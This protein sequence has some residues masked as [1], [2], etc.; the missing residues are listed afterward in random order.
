M[1]GFRIE[2]TW[3]MNVQERMKSLYAEHV[4]DV[5]FH[6][7]H[8]IEFVV[9]KVPEFA[10]ELGADV[11]K[12][13]LAALVHDV[14]HLVA[15]GSHVGAGE[16]LLRQILEEAECPSSVV[17]SVAR[18]VKEAET[19]QRGHS[20]SREA[21]ALS[22]ADTLFK[23]LPI[24]P[25]LL[26]PRYLAEAKWPID[27]LARKIISE[28]TPLQREGIYFYSSSAKAKFDKSAQ[29]NLALWIGVIECLEDPD[30]ARLE[31]RLRG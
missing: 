7:W 28:Q 24:T 18:I 9:S 19:A 10:L 11:D 30:V 14:N 12:T 17:S 8:H 2:A 22:D 1:S 13:R 26:A 27:K 21:K 15:P 3:I 5:P 25:I 6:G 23:A 31:T 16:S 4:D 20:L 29:L